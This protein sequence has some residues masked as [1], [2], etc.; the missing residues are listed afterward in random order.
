MDDFR[1][2]VRAICEKVYDGAS[3]EALWSEKGPGGEYKRDPEL[4]M[5]PD[6]AT[7]AIMSA[8][9]RAPG[10]VVSPLVWREHSGPAWVAATP[11][12]QYAIGKLVAGGFTAQFSGG[13]SVGDFDTLEAAKA[14]CQADFAK[15]ITSAVETKNSADNL[16]GAPSI[17]TDL[18]SAVGPSG[19]VTDEMVDA[20]QK[21]FQAQ[22]Q[23]RHKARFPKGQVGNWEMSAEE[24]GFRAML[25]VAPIAALP[26]LTEEEVRA[27][28]VSEAIAAL[29]ASARKCDATWKS[30]NPLGRWKSLR[31]ALDRYDR[32]VS[33][34]QPRG[35]HSVIKAAIH[36]LA[37][38]A[39]RSELTIDH[40]HDSIG[41]PVRT[42]LSDWLR[43]PERSLTNGG[44]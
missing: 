32:A 30:G 11:F 23:V 4:E 13:H 24:A 21:A 34:N 15:R 17:Q 35:E 3:S 27:D 16:D 33:A 9:K 25:A 39:D 26:S 14:A 29:V 41:R 36:K 38:E 18:G 5:T 7:A 40:G 10:A 42:K 28:E 1:E 44:E 8:F 43:S 20:F 37:L 22:L 6:E 19:V 12:G 2:E 31:E